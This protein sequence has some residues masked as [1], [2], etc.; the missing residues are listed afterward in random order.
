MPFDLHLFLST[1]DLLAEINHAFQPITVL[2]QQKQMKIE[3]HVESVY[4]NNAKIT[5]AI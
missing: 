3:L 5:N 4:V 2:C 1:E